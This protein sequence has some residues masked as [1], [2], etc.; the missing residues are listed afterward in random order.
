LASP[1]PTLRWHRRF[2]APREAQYHFGW[3][4]LREHFGPAGLRLDALRYLNAYPPLGAL[5]GRS[6]SLKL[7]RSLSALAGPLLGRVMIARFR[8][9]ATPR[10]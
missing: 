1:A 4:G 9:R 5:A 6:W 10:D 3:R 8:R 2:R 7:D